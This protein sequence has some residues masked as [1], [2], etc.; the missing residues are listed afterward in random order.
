MNMK[1]MSFNT[2][3]YMFT[4][5]GRTRKLFKYIESIN[6]D[7]VGFQE[8][9]SHSLNYL[10]TNLDD[11]YIVT[12]NKS[13][14]IPFYGEYNSILVNKKYK[15]KSYKTYALYED[16]NKIRKKGKNDNFPRICVVC[17]FE[18]DK[19]SYLIVNTH[20][21][22][23]DSDN[24]IKQLKILKS[25]IDK[26]LKDKEHLILL[27]DFNMS[28]DNKR[29]YEF[30]KNNKYLDPFKDEKISSFPSKPNMKMIDHILLDKNFKIKDKIIDVESNDFGYISDHYPIIC[31]IELNTK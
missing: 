23:S 27:G 9:N 16:I 12:G 28:L 26:E 2:K 14:F 7:I 25:I 3:K 4:K 19:I 24:K 1:I 31:E 20:I 29:F 22:N 5:F 15:I 8:L 17:H 11:Y 30:I 13:S 6:A 10:I 18:Y 21:D